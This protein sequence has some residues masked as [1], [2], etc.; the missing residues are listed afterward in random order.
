MWFDGICINWLVF[1]KYIEWAIT[2]ETLHRGTYRALR[3]NRGKLYV[4]DPEYCP[5][6]LTQVN[7]P[8]ASRTL[9]HV[10]HSILIIYT[11]TETI[12]IEFVWWHAPGANQINENDICTLTFY[13]SR[14]LLKKK[15]SVVSNEAVRV[16]TRKDVQHANRVAMLSRWLCRNTTTRK[17]WPSR[18]KLVDKEA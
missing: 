3:G 12:C 17:A 8:Q 5:T 16:Y 18:D 4:W 13:W 1:D 2:N 10:T 6:M 14:T 7:R 9:T 15:L 11:F